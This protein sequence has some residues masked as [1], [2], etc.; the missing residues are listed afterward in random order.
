VMYDNAFC[1]YSTLESR[2]MSACFQRFTLSAS[3]SKCT[4]WEWEEKQM[5][6]KESERFWF[7][8]YPCCWCSRMR[9][10]L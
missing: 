3:H 6:I 5:S 4:K 2:G 7:F 9:Q 8:G 10:C 1:C